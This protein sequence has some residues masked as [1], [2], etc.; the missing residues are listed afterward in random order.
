MSGHIFL[1][2]S[3]ERGYIIVAGV[4]LPADLVA[5]RKAMR[6]LVMPGCGLGDQGDIDFRTLESLR[7]EQPAKARANHHHPVSTA[8]GVTVRS[9]LIDTAKRTQRGR[10]GRPRCLPVDRR[11]GTTTAGRPIPDMTSS[12][13]GSTSSTHALMTSTPGSRRR[14]SSS[15]SAMTP[16]LAGLRV[17]WATATSAGLMSDSCRS[18]HS[19]SVD[20]RSVHSQA[21]ATLD[22]RP[23]EVGAH[24][25]AQ[26]GDGGLDGMLTGRMPARQLAQ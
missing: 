3:K 19:R 12:I 17:P 21:V 1:D 23:H 6:T 2:E 5:A 8:R 13:V 26:P 11:R 9:A 10:P 22:D 16:G 18:L 15:R 20:K 14:T 25:R 4:V 7:G 24:G